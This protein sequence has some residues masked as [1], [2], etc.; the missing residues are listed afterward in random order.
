[1]TESISNQNQHFDRDAEQ[2]CADEQA[3]QR[4]ESPLL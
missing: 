1:M 4:A 3:D 2:S